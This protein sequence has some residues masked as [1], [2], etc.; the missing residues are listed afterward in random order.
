V[1]FIVA[2]K[3]APAI[4][5]H[6]ASFTGDAGGAAI[7]VDFTGPAVEPG[8]YTVRYRARGDAGT[9]TPWAYDRSIMVEPALA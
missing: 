3:D 7:A 9:T 5:E 1:G 6:D 8:E 2:A 4:G